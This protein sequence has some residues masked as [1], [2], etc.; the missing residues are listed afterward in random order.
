MEEQNGV[1]FG[2]G[3]IIYFGDDDFKM[4][5]GLTDVFID[6]MLISGSQLAKKDSE[7]RLVAYLGECDQNYTGLGVVGF[8]IVKMPWDKDSFEDDKQFMLDVIKH[9]RELTYDEKIWDIL[10][11]QPNHEHIEYALD[12]FERLITKMT[13]DDIKEESL[14]DWLYKRGIWG[15]LISCHKHGT[16]MSLCGCKLCGDGCRNAET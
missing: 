16:I 8:N 15:G 13:K 2:M 4:S 3:N 14:K 10:M 9:A 1:K 6:Y 5:N 11:Y 12:S 7:K